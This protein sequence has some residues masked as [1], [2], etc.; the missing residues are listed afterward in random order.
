MLS[1]SGWFWIE[2]YNEREPKKSSRFAVT[3]P[4]CL[5]IPIVLTVDGM[6]L[7]FGFKIVQRLKSSPTASVQ[8]RDRM[9]AMSNRILVGALSTFTVV[10]LLLI[11][12]IAGA[13]HLVIIEDMFIYEDYDRPYQLLGY[14]ILWEIEHVSAI[15]IL[16]WIVRVR[17]S[18]EE[19][20][21]MK[22]GAHLCARDQRSEIENKVI[23][24][25]KSEP[26]VVSECVESSLSD[27]S[28]SQMYRPLCEQSY[29][30]SV[31]RWKS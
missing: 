10:Q 21:N 16:T 6:L 26:F 22:D 14:A 4:V 28:H 29:V 12:G 23:Y 2:A 31:P 30:P 1:I 8:T 27:S 20:G 15:M 5:I 18:S 11:T 17:S 3:F 24:L 9:D 13:I 7:Q 25:R 19:T